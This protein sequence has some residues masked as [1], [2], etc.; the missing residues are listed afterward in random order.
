MKIFDFGSKWDFVKVANLTQNRG[1]SIKCRIAQIFMFR[2]KVV[3]F[4]RFIKGLEFVGIIRKTFECIFVEYVTL[5][6]ENAVVLKKL[7][8]DFN[9]KLRFEKLTHSSLFFY[10][11][12]QIRK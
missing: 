5:F 11:Y 7:N 3:R 9:W 6:H 4:H 10:I 12:T 8:N 1:Q 2:C